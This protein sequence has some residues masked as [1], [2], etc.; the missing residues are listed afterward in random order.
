MTGTNRKLSMPDR[1][2][3]L[4]DFGFYTVKETAHVLRLPE[5]RVY[6]LEAEDHIPRAEGMG[7][8]LLFLGATIKDYV[9]LIKQRA[10]ERQEKKGGLGEA[11]TSPE[12]KSK[13]A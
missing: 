6:W 4:E 2:D 12:P 5:K 7:G 10:R 13:S 3:D 8:S 9:R 11:G 1:V